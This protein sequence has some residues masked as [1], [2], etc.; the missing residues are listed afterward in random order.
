MDTFDGGDLEDLL[1]DWRPETSLD[2]EEEWGC[3]DGEFG[4]LNFDHD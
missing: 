2:E 3:Y 1:D 4:E